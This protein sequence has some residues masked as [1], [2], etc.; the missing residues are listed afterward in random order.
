MFRVKPITGRPK[1]Q[2]QKVVY[3]AKTARPK[4]DD[5]AALREKVLLRDGYTCRKCG[6]SLRN[7]MY[8]EIHHIIP[9]SRGGSNKMFNLLSLCT[10]CHE[11]EH[12]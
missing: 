11:K 3:R 2:N 6:V 7:T 12:R 1:P 8:R 10:P 9:V 5:W 4:E